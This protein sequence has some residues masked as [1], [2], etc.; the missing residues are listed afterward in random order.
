[1]SNSPQQQVYPTQRQRFSRLDDDRGITLRQYYA[2]L[3]M[4]G[5]VA[6]S[7]VRDEPENIAR[8]SIQLAD[9]L[10]HELGRKL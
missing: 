10:L 3:A 1:M 5:L 4:Q 6:D 7:N 2:G 9:A 8:V